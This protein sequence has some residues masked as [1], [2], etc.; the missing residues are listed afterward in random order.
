M[1]IYKREGTWYIRTWVTGRELRLAVGP[2]KRQAELALGKIKAEAAEGRFIEPA[3]GHKVTYRE[4]LERY[5]RDHS[6]PRK[7]PN[8]YRSDVGFAKSLSLALGALLLKDVTAEKVTAYIES[9]RRRGL[10]PASINRRLALL[11]HSFTL[12]KTWGLIRYS[13]VAEVKLLP[14]RNRRLRYVDPAEFQ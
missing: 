3:K 8:S 2:S 12:A 9:E 10:K 7:C 1:G 13:P 4:L 14:E 6:A 5:L 11:K